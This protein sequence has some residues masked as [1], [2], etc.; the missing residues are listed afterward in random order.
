MF[1]LFERASVGDLLVY[2]TPFPY[3]A[4]IHEMELLEA[5]AKQGRYHKKRGTGKGTTKEK[6]RSS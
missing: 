1:K 6:L 4:S 5:W 3:F 2:D